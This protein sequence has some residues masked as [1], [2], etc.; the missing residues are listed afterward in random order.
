MEFSID[1]YKSGNGRKYAKEFLDELEAL[2]S[3]LWES[4]FGALTQKLKYKEFHRMPLCKFL[5][6]GVWELRAH[7]G[8][9]QA[10]ITF[11]YGPGRKIFLLNGFI[12]KD[13]KKQQK[14]IKKAVSLKRELESREIK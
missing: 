5:G 6:E 4:I 14:E 13:K 7:S 3:E 2:N 12:K 1:F 8:N 9:D 10:R 11:C